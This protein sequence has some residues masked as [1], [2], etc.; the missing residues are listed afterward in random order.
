MTRSMLRAIFRNAPRPAVQ[1]ETELQRHNRGVLH[2]SDVS[3]VTLPPMFVV[4]RHPNPNPS[5]EANRLTHEQGY[6]AA[7]IAT[8]RV[9]GAVHPR[10]RF[11][12]VE[13]P[14]EALGR[15][16]VTMYPDNW[17]SG[18]EHKI[19]V[20]RPSPNQETNNKLYLTQVNIH[21]M[22]FGWK[23]VSSCRF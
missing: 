23:Q 17:L 8:E 5:I 19:I 12:L 22:R 4:W 14:L 11:T 20:Q 16:I 6:S 1:V 2:E 13:Q 9:G 7:C 10:W 21:D 18:Q 15:C 3:H